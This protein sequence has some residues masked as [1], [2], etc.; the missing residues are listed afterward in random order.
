MI[1]LRTHI[2][3]GFS[4]YFCLFLIHTPKLNKILL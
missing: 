3:Y 2:T 1:T 4:F